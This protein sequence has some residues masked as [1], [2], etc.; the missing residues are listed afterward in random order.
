MKKKLN[1]AVVL[2]QLKLHWPLH[3]WNFKV[4]RMSL[5]WFVCFLYRLYYWIIHTTDFCIQL[6]L[7]TFFSKIS[8]DFLL[9][10]FLKSRSG[11]CTSPLPW[12][13]YCY[14]Q[15]QSPA[16]SIINTWGIQLR[17]KF[18]LCTFGTSGACLRLSMC[19]KLKLRKS[20]MWAR[21]GW[22]TS[23]SGS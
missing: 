4:G 18:L 23:L 12:I 21:L 22:L 13:I 7:S 19:H 15:R 16:S 9:D 8:A 3:R 1:F 2:I 6:E 14:S 10:I 5:H 20:L 11:I 17:H